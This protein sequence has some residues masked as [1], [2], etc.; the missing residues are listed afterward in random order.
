MGEFEGVLVNYNSKG[1]RVRLLSAA[2]RRRDIVTVT[3]PE[4][5]SSRVGEVI[6]LVEKDRSFGVKF[7][8]K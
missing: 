6:H 7:K 4:L 1:A 5:G 8:R 3:A 2:V